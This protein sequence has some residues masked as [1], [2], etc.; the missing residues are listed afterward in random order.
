MFTLSL[1]NRITILCRSCLKISSSS[2]PVCRLTC[3]P[4]FVTTSNESLCHPPKVSKSSV[5]PPWTEVLDYKVHRVRHAKCTLVQFANILI[6]LFCSS[7]RPR[8]SY[9]AK[10]LW[11]RPGGL[12]EP[13]VV[14]RKSIICFQGIRPIKGCY[15]SQLFMIFFGVRFTSNYDYLYSETDF[16]Q[17]IFIQLLEF[18]FPPY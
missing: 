12:S 18:T 10:A 1:T 7:L 6:Q 8:T 13:I 15:Y 17:V 4:S 14:V 11:S 9:N 2:F 5:F 3:L 16:T